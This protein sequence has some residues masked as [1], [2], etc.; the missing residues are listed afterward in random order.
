MDALCLGRILAVVP[1]SSSY[2]VRIG[3]ADP[4]ATGALHQPSVCSPVKWS[5]LERVI[6]GIV[7]RAVALTFGLVVHLD[8]E[9]IVLAVAERFAHAASPSIAR[10]PRLS[11][12][13][14]LSSSGECQSPPWHG[15]QR[16]RGFSRLR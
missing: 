16:S 7:D 14:A 8:A 6:G 9:A 10:V 13:L 1:G 5:I 2:V 12:R 15:A 11:S 3:V 4:V